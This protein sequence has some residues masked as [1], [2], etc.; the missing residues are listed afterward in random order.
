MQSSLRLSITA[1]LN[2]VRCVGRL[3]ELEQFL[4]VFNN[5][6]AVAM[7]LVNLS[8]PKVLGEHIQRQPTIP[9]RTRPLLAFSYQR[10]PNTLP[11]S[12]ARN[13][14]IRD[15]TVFFAHVVISYGL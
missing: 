1:G 7:L 5:V 6:L 15:V 13:N 4:N 10:T 12:S 9:L 2:R 11:L 14:K 8:R 3:V